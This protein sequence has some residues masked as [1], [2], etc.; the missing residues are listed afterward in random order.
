MTHSKRGDAGGGPT[1]EDD[2]EEK[3]QE[4]EEFPRVTAKDVLAK[5]QRDPEPSPH[6][7]T[8]EEARD[9]V[10]SMIRHE[11]LI[12]HHIASFNK[13]ITQHA[14]HIVNENS[15]LVLECANMRHVVRFQDVMVRKPTIREDDGCIRDITP[16]ECILRKQTY[17]ASLY[18]NVLHVE[19]YKKIGEDGTIDWIP[20]KRTLNENV[21]LC[22]IPAMVRS[23]VCHTADEPDIMDPNAPYEY[24][25]NFIISGSEKVLVPQ[26]KLRINRAFIFKSNK[27]KYTLMAE[28]RSCHEDKLR[29]T[30]TLTIRMT[31]VK[32]IKRF[33]V[34][35]PYIKKAVPIFAV[36][37]LLGFRTMAEA[38]RCVVSAG[39]LSGRRPFPKGSP[40]TT[41]EMRDLHYWVM[42][43]FCNEKWCRC[44]RSSGADEEGTESKG[45]YMPDFSMMSYEEIIDWIGCIGTLKPTK[46]ERYKYVHHLMANEFLPH[47]GVK[48]TPDVLVRKR[49]F[50][51]YLVYRLAM[52]GFEPK[53]RE[54]DDK[55][56]YGN[57]QIETSGMLMSLCLRQNWRTLL[58]KLLNSL[59]KDVKA[60]KAI[61]VGDM[62]SWK[63][64]TDNF[65]F[66]LA[67]GKWGTKKGAST[68]T[69]I[70]Q[71]MKRMCHMTWL[72]HLRKLNVP[73]NREGKNPKP[74]MLRFSHWGIAC[75]ATTPEGQPCGLIKALAL[76]ARVTTGVR[77]DV[78][79]NVIL[80]ALEPDE[81]RYFPGT[82]YDFDDGN[83]VAVTALE[84]DPEALDAA[85]DALDDQVMGSIGESG[86]EVAATLMI[87]GIPMA[88]VSKP[89]K[90]VKMIREM[91][92]S[93]QVP[94]ETSV[95]Y[96]KQLG[97]VYVTCDA[98]GTRRP[99]YIIPE[100]GS[101]AD[102]LVKVRHI[103]DVYGGSS[104]E[105]W[106]Q[107]M[108]H[109]CIEYVDKHEEE[110]S[111]LVW[112]DPQK[113]APPT[114]AWTH[115]EI[116]PLIIYGESTTLIPFSNHN[117]AP[118]NTYQSSMGQAAIGVP[119]VELYNRTSSHV[120]FYPT[121]P[122]VSSFMEEA[123]GL[124]QLPAGQNMVI[125]ILP[126]GS[127]QEDSLVFNQ[128]AIDAGLFR[129]FYM[130]TYSEDVQKTI[131]VDAERFSKPDEYCT[132]MKA[133]NY[134]KLQ[135]NGFPM[136]GER[137]KDGDV[138]IGK[139]MLIHNLASNDKHA[140]V[141]RDQSETI[142]RFDKEAVVQSVT[143]S[144][145]CNDRKQGCVHMRS[146]RVPCQ[147]DKFASRHAQ[148]GVI[149]RIVP[150]ADMPFS[151]RTGI[152]PSAIMNPLA[153][154]SR[155]TVGHLIEMFVG[156]AAAL[157]GR[158][159][160]GTAF[161][162]VDI[163]SIGEVLET[164]GFS[165]SGKEPMID[166][167]TGKLM[168]V[169]VYMGP[170]FYQRLRQMVDDKYHARS[171]GQRQV[172]T[173][174]ATE[175]RAREGGLRLGEME[176]DCIAANGATQI[177]K[178]RFLD[179]S[180]DYITVVCSICGLIAE[181]ARALTSKRKQS[182]VRASKPY[183]RRCKR[184]DGVF[185][186]RMPYNYKLLVQEVMGMGA[187]MRFELEEPMYERDLETCASVGLH[188]P[189]E[190]EVVKTKR[191]KTMT[192]IQRD[193]TLLTGAY[194]SLVQ[195]DV[196]QDTTGR[197][198]NDL[199]GRPPR[200]V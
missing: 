23:C 64:I 27:T 80:Y 125:A 15:I 130:R 58:R 178:D 69:G 38:A 10:R 50:F 118:R 26:E 194:S 142:K 2:E 159:G 95:V 21:L 89:L 109:K 77:S 190:A 57:K 75:P 107:L 181:P 179:Q 14:P 44:T 136:V 63:T 174:Q 144:S 197:S 165:K 60:N 42:T 100:D 96:D 55:D 86:D 184:S 167:V 71:P 124:H 115:C 177:T 102:T 192:T 90:V 72:A 36:F 156:K 87:N 99:L 138:V 189:P 193:P 199:I 116:H 173:R 150:D 20:T 121:R 49:R 154:P 200:P 91:R 85:I 108:L 16:Q 6:I 110:Q 98:G 30:S 162:D 25:G 182:M 61:N 93:F 126:R 171:R 195:D 148:K 1:I 43:V 24:G 183:C 78:M 151:M 141:A 111:L 169:D 123:M 119:G 149:G 68:Q 84:K 170:I 131:G 122:L 145:T 157:E 166:G 7:L 128:A 152:R 134:E 67:T 47:V 34:D 73:L 168:E 105:V 187:A 112:M 161:E 54:K 88:L 147:G 5:R 56:H 82:T 19:E 48:N 8:K 62:V 158:L 137:L 76:G 180:D 106:R 22:E 132:G 133:A 45:K 12:K 74:R 94:P 92:R 28:I 32:G 31:D 17:A 198:L 146:V 40:W 33:W 79:A 9:V 81:F 70:S 143:L 129:T 13:F 175:G 163:D 104:V 120:L 101:M 135:A 41:A 114:E 65:K 185:K 37:R 127:N 29:S 139:Q 97:E 117:P 59:R 160:D 172:T 83:L 196:V 153:L 103:L 188:V 140:M 35:I 66:A 113:P 46:E 164:Y 53:L 3:I 176:R 51:A 155:M 186:V 4:P 191:M 39:R 11:G 18:A 52:C